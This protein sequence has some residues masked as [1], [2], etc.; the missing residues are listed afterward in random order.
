[1]RIDLLLVA[2]FN[3]VVVWVLIFLHRKFR[4]SQAKCDGEWIKQLLQEQ[5]QLETRVFFRKK[6]VVDLDYKFRNNEELQQF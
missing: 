1:M 3:E 2:V 4:P 6:N 5:F